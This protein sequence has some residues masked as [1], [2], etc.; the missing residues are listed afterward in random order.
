MERL[1]QWFGSSRLGREVGIAAHLQE[2]Y[3]EEELLDLFAKRL[4]AYEDTGLEPEEVKDMAENAETSLLTW[5][6]SR[7]GFPVGELMGMCEAKQKGRFAEV[8]PELRGTV[9]LLR[10]R[11][12]KAKSQSFV[13]D[14]A[15]YAL[16]Q[17]WKAVR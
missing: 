6:E 10:K 7:Y 4:A 16:Y 15:A 2:Q 12:E 9:E 1:T 5:F 14:P 11:Y 17:V 8:P 3:T 13:R